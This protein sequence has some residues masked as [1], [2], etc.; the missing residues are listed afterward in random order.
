MGS[1]LLTPATTLTVAVP[2]FVESCW[3]VAVIVNVPAL[4]LLNNPLIGLT[5]PP[6]A[7][8]VTFGL[9]LPL[10]FTV[11]EQDDDCPV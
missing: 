2:N 4:A 7:D 8:Q 3:D 10:P 6:L 1:E 9:K 11:A 5:V